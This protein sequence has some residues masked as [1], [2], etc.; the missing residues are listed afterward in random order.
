MALD[1][2]AERIA[3]QHAIDAAAVKQPREAGVVARQHRDRLAARTHVGQLQQRDRLGRRCL[4]WM[5]AHAARL[6]YSRL[7]RILSMRDSSS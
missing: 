6:K 2:H 1:D 5:N 3:D 7:P 4:R